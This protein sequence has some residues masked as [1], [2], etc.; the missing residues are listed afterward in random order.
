MNPFD[1]RRPARRVGLIET[2]IITLMMIGAG[3]GLSALTAHILG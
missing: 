3:L 2:V 1:P